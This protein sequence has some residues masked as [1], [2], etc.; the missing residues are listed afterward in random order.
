VH[1]D[2]GASINPPHPDLNR[3]SA[4]LGCYLPKKYRRG[5]RAVWYWNAT[6]PLP[7]LVRR[8]GNLWSVTQMS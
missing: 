6:F 2:S 3:S 8:K 1:S 4:P 7:S 5:R